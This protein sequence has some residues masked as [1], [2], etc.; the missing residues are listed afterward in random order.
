M[1]ILP[2]AFGRRFLAALNP[3]MR[4]FL[5]PGWHPNVFTTLGCLVWVAAGAAFFMGRLQLGGALV[6]LGG[7]V[8]T[9]DGYVARERGIDSAFG[10]FYDS[11][12]DRVAEVAV[13]VGLMSLYGGTGPRTI[14]EPWMIYVIALA[15]GGSL[16]VSYTRAKAE[17]EG[18]SCS[19]GI[20]QRAE[21]I[22]LLGGATLLFGS[23][24]NGVVLTWVL[25]AMAV[26]TN[27]T[28]FYR[29]YWVWR[30]TRTPDAPAPAGGP[31]AARET[32]N[33]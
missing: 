12:L 27:A 8:D 17:S 31:T 14:G 22:L 2:S 3:L 25:I 26:L 15:L 28:A 30:Q 13:F 7:F 5:L 32:I 9:I 19:V 16:M 21:R 6:L 24:E 4:V 33:T 18:F 20:M 23:W 10:S 29:I 1:K 11:V